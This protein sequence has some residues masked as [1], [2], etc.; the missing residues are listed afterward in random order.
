MLHYI[1]VRDGEDAGV[2]DIDVG[3]ETCEDGAEQRKMI[4]D[5]KIQKKRRSTTSERENPNQRIG[6][7]LS[8][9]ADQHDQRREP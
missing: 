5:R 9:A 8:R 6:K 1:T 3:V 2:V 7:R 4:L